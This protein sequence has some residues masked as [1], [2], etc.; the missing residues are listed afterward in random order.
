MNLESNE[1]GLFL[2]T[3]YPTGNKAWCAKITGLDVKFKFS[4]EFINGTRKG[5]KTVKAEEGEI[6]EEVV[7]SHSGKSRNTAYYKIV[8][9]EFSHISEKEVVVQFS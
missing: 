2:T 8:N 4:R 7:F 9:G 6:F 5:E 1:K 3:S